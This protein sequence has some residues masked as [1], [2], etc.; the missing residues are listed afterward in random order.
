MIEI[1][2]LNLSSVTDKIS[3]GFAIVI[4]LSILAFKVLLIHSVYTTW[5]VLKPDEYYMF[6]EFFVG[7]KDKKYAR[8]YPLASS[9]RKLL[10][11]LVAVLCTFIPVWAQLLVIV[12]LQFIYLAVLIK[13][14]PMEEVSHN[15]IEIINEVYFLLFVGG[16]VHF[17]KKSRWSDS[18]DSVFANSLILN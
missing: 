7:L 12:F 15:I 13:M 4:A 6:K 5:N 8:L 17:H 9:F 18:S 14:R 1:Q 10:F 11:V 2:K 16:L 3:F